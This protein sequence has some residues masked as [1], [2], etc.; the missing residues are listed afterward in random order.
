MS[1]TSRSL[2]SVRA[3][4]ADTSRNDTN[5]NGNDNGSPSNGSHNGT[6]LG[7][8]GRGSISARTS[9]VVMMNGR[10]RVH[11]RRRTVPPS[12]LHGIVQMDNVRV[13]APRHSFG[14]QHRFAPNKLTYVSAHHN[15]DL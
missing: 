3:R 15:S 9:S 2:P 8:G 12:V 14:V 6:L 11:R 7:G 1:Q 4:S 13:A 10:G 5:A